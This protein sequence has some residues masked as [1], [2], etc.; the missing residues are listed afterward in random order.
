MFEC[1]A[2]CTAEG[3]QVDRAFITGMAKTPV[4]SVWSKISWCRLITPFGKAHCRDSSIDY[5][6]LPTSEHLTSHSQSTDS[7]VLRI[8]HSLSEDRGRVV[9]VLKA[10]LFEAGLTTTR[11]LQ[12]IFIT[13]NAVMYECNFGGPWQ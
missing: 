13:K 6:Q 9:E 7:K 2:W 12:Q 11:A 10:L 4:L 5:V 8:S 3:T 1:T